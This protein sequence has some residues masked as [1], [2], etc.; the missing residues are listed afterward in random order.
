M[1][2]ARLPSY[3]HYNVSK[4]TAI[5]VRVS[6]HEKAEIKRRAVKQGK[7]T[8]PFLRDLALQGYSPPKREDIEEV[9]DQV[10]E[11]IVGGTSDR[12]SVDLEVEAKRIWLS[13]GVPMP[14]ARRRAQ[15]RFS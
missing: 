5:Q 4:G 15:E 7:K 10:A 3:C 12:S 8:G 13:E 1:T 11:Q 2:S 14:E 9:A 6:E